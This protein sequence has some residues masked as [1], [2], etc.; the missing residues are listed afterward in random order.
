MKVRHLTRKFY[1][2]QVI[3]PK[4]EII[5]V[6]SIYMYMYIFIYVQKNV[7]VHS[8]ACIKRSPLGQRKSDIIRQLTS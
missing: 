2:Q 8:Q 6:T 4:Y 7:H 3:T 1:D 5:F